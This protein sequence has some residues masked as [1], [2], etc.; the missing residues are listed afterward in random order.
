[1]N[2]RYVINPNW[3]NQKVKVLVIGAGGTGSVLLSLLA[4]MDYNLKQLSDHQSGIDVSIADGDT[5][6]EFNIGRQAFYPTDIGCYKAEVLAHRFNQFFGTSW[7]FTNSMIDPVEDFN[8]ISK[9]DIVI[10]CVDSA[11]FRAELGKQVD[12]QGYRETL[13]LDCGNDQN[14][15]QVILGHLNAISSQQRLPNI[16][17]LYGELLESIEDRPEDSCSHAASLAKQD[18]GINHT[19]AIHANN[20]LWQLLRHGEL[21]EHGC[22]VTLTD[23][24]VT[25]L[26]INE[27]H[28][29]SFGFQLLDS[30]ASEDSET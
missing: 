3:I 10:T 17:E 18:F 28:W 1:M 13:W 23:N 15:S 26:P 7:R 9:F 8:Q 2:N 6:S 16:Y 30:D 21:S 25:A 19:T 22:F 20:I 27:Q 29:A 12:H 11:K 14:Q 4:Q 5:I 24:D